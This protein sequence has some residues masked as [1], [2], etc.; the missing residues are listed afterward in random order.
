MAWEVKHTGDYREPPPPSKR[1]ALNRYGEPVTTVKG[2]PVVATGPFKEDLLARY[3]Q[4]AVDKITADIEYKKRY[5][6]HYSEDCM[7][8][9]SRAQ[10]LEEREELRRA[11]VDATLSLREAKTIAYS[12]KQT[13]SDLSNQINQGIEREIQIEKKLGDKIK[14]LEAKL[15]EALYRPTFTAIIK[16]WLAAKLKRNP[17]QLT[18]GPY[19]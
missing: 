11:Y 15:E 17:P 16:D 8:P 10:Q 5:A 7:D 13:I 9:Y 14:E 2:K 6:H 3:A 19:R 4:K 1:F 18:N 12:Q